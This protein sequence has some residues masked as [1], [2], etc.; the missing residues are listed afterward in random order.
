MKRNGRTPKIFYVG[1]AL[2]CALLV[3]SHMMGGLYARYTSGA[4]GA[5]SARVAK[6]AFTESWGMQTQSIPLSGAELIPGGKIT[7]PV[8][9]ENNGEVTIRY[10]VKVE[11]L[12]GNLPITVGDLANETIG[13]GETKNFNIEIEWPS[14]QS[15]TD[16]MG[17]MDILRVSVTVEQVD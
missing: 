2:L 17:K 3:T 5:S 15:K 10:T 7:V 11:N 12:T 9:V 13:I 6:F 4:E 14:D 16:Y 1:V 8:T